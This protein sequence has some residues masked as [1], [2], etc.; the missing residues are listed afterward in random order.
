[1]LGVL[2]MSVALGFVRHEYEG[3]LEEY[4]ALK[5]AEGKI[6]SVT[7]KSHVTRLDHFN[8]RDKRNFSLRYWENDSFFTGPNKDNVILYLCGEWTCSYPSV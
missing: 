3:N 8:L 1:M 4:L 2:V 6:M 5:A 7:E